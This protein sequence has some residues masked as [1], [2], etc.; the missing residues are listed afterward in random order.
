MEIP[1][2]YKGD[3]RKLMVVP[4][5]LVIISLF[6]IPRI[7]LGIE[8]RGGTLITL[9]TDG[10]VDTV[11]LQKELT[12]A[13][14]KVR[15]VQLVESSIGT[16]VE[17]ELDEYP[18]LSQAEELK[19][20]FYVYFENVSRLYANYLITNKT[21]Q[22]LYHE[23][24]QQRAKLD[25][26]VNQ[27]F[28]LASYTP[29]TNLSPNVSGET[30]LNLVKQEFTN[31]YLKLKH[32]Y[33]EKLG[34]VLRNHVRYSSIS[35]DTVSPSLSSKFI[36]RAVQVTV[37]SLIFVILLTFAVFRVPAPSV[38]VLTGAL[39]DII[40]ALG[41]M[42]LFGIPLTLSSFA[43][44]LMMLGFSLD[45]DMMLTIKMLK[46]KRGDL[47]ERA[48]DAMRTGMTM[49]T[50]DFVAFVVLLVLGIVANISTYYE[51]ASVAVCG[52]IGDLI[53]TWMF[54]A[55]MVLWYLESRKK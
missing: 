17:I 6:L 50:T 15:R 54:N 5:F 35:V 39:F 33:E 55:P 49:S 29:N 38:A 41:A 48:Y 16:T 20:E 25:E 27:M 36:D 34:E 45:T 1:N 8:F 53:A 9:L 18:K 51:I 40:M 10:P 46:I 44:L 21:N 52:L 4:I 13:G 11:Q 32:D 19:G 47:R 23:Y 31:A 24:V 28:S 2:I 3:Y 12:E 42:G 14:I 43:A 7:Q 30:N 22:T 26:I 37:I